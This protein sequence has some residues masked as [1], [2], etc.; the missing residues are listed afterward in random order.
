MWDGTVFRVVHTKVAD[1]SLSIQ[2]I[3][4]IRTDNGSNIGFHGATPGAVLFL[5]A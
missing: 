4:I 3:C 1:C 5:P 2:F